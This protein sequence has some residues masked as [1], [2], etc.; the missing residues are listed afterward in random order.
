MSLL[1]VARDTLKEIPMADILRERLSLALDQ[2][3]DAERTIGALQQESGG[4][5]KQLE[6]EYSA[7]Q[8]LEKE[9]EQVRKEHEEDIRIYHCIEFRLG[10]RT[11]REWM[12]FCPKCHLPA[13]GYEAMDGSPAISCSAS[14]GW[15]NVIPRPLEILVQELRR[16]DEPVPKDHG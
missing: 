12:A 5:R 15:Q 10:R 8:K 14:C 16:R 3:G 9:L 1:E 13:V 4:L 7:R 2:L 11:G 6:L